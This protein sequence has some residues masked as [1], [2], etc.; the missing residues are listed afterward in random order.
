M[1]TIVSGLPRCGTSMMMQML[2]AGGHPV[3]T[4]RIRTADDSN[5]RGYF[6]LEI[7]KQIKTDT[8]WLPEAEG[9]AFK[10]VSMLL[11]HLPPDREYRIVFMD[12]DLDEM[13]ASQ[14]EMLQRMGKPVSAQ[15]NER[16]KPMFQ[17]H[18]RDVKVWLAQQKNVRVM[19]CNH[20]DVLLEPRVQADRI[21][22]FLD[23]AV[24]AV[25]MAAAVD[26]SLYRQRKG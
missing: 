12:R 19:Y 4:D 17:N 16:M 23:G 3:F 24:D 21:A 25:K 20:R 15:D 18:L 6:E 9:K 1:I 22:A 5:P 13:L 14:T 10:M 7:A 8:S 11:F 2:Y 26:R